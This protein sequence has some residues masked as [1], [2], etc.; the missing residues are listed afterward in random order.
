MNTTIEMTRKPY[1]SVLTG[2]PWEIVKPF[3]EERHPHNWGRPRF[4]DTREVIN[5]IG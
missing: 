5:A 4:V 3:F 1:D 2:D